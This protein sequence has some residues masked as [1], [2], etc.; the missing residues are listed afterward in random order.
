MKKIKIYLWL[1][2]CLLLFAACEKEIDFTGKVT[3]SEIVISSFIT[4]DSVIKA[5]VS[6]SRFFLNDDYL[7]KPIENAVVSVYV[8]G[9]LREN[10]QHQS[11][12][13]YKA[14]FKP[15]VGDIVK[16]IAKVSSMKDLS[17]ET[18]IVQPSELIQ[19]DTIS[20]WTGSKPILDTITTTTNNVSST[21]IVVKGKY[22]FRTINFTLTFKDN[23]TAKNY[24]RL[25]VDKTTV[26]STKVNINY[27]YS[28]DD[29]ISGNT[30]EVVPGPPST[31]GKNL[32]HVFSDEMI[33]GTQYPLIFSMKDTITV[34]DPA[35]ARPL[36]IKTIHVDLQNTS[37]SFYLYL[38]TLDA[39]ASANELFSEPIQI[40]TNV[41]G[42]IGILGSYTS[43]V[44]AVELN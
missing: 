38:K 44:W 9:T 7:F 22:R 19:L 4:P 5:Q 43:N 39:K 34:Y 10:M 2:C 15:M 14:S 26:N 36:P 25:V 28:L 37:K 3:D 18:D 17:C 8:N 31:L 27:E 11:N 42:G 23:L 16:L 21:Q 6:E 13:I 29:I 35:Y 12:G 1:W 24:Y 40:Y 32:Y 30:K 33:N 41:V 20:T